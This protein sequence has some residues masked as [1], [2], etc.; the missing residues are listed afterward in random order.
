M[1][2]KLDIIARAASRTGNRVITSL[3]DGS[4]IA[5]LTSQHYEGIVEEYLT[6]HGWKFAREV[7]AMQ[8]TALEPE[9]PWAQVWRKPTGLLS[10][11]YAQDD[12]GRRVEAEERSTSQGACVVVLREYETLYAVGTYRVDESEWPADFAAAVQHRMEGVFYG[13]VAEQHEQ[14]RDA[15]R[16]AE[17]KLQRARVRD[18]RA[19][20]PTDAGP[21]DLAAA[22]TRSGAWRHRGYR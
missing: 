19:S 21:W 9:E 7:N 10:L 15:E 22:R 16:T 8:L 2:S 1:T 13:G 11:H 4:E 6:Q 17:G 5:Q 18:Q 3:D 14:A 12:C 20:T